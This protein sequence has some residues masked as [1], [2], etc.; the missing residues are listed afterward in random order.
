MTGNTI[1]IGALTNLQANFEVKC[2]QDNNC[3]TNASRRALS[4]WRGV[5][6]HAAMTK[7]KSVYH[8][9]RFPA[10]VISHAVRWYFR[11]QLSLRDIEEL[12]FEC[13]VTVSHETIRRWRDKFGARALPIG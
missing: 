12:L 3:S 4:R 9:H 1:S 2:R 5:R 7:T 10:T 11:F 6:E 13:S 8:G